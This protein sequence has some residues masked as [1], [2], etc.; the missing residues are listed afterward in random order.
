[1]TWRATLW[2]GTGG[3]GGRGS[4]GATGIGG[5]GM[6]FGGGGLGGGGLATG[7]G[8]GAT[9]WSWTTAGGTVAGGLG[10][11]KNAP[12]AAISITA[13]SKKARPKPSG[14]DAKLAAGLVMGISSL[15]KESSPFLKKRTKKL[16]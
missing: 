7:A 2:C 6:G 14:A 10:A 15:T 4:G 9:I 16:L 11:R 5:A 3:G 8:A 13:A 1:M 12:T